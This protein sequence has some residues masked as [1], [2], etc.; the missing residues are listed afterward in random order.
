MA[1]QNK[2][3]IFAH[4]PETYP[5]A[6]R[7]LIIES[8][9]LDLDAPLPEG[10]V[11]VK[12]LVLSIDPVFRRMMQSQGDSFKDIPGYVLG[13][14][15]SGPVFGK[16]LRSNNDQFKQDDFV[17]TL[18]GQV[19]EYAVYP[20]ELAP[21]LIVR[22]E[23]KTSG[24]PI[25]HYLNGLGFT[26]FTAYV[27]LFLVANVQ[28]GQSIYI[29]AAAGAVGHI[30]GQLAKA[31]GLRV[32][33]SAG[34]DE[35]V[36]ILKEI[37]FDGA[38]NY[39]TDDADA[40]LKEFEPNGIDIYFDN[41]GSKQLEL[42]IRHLKPFGKI[43]VCGMVSTY[44][45]PSAAPPPNNLI[46]IVG[47]RLQING[48]MAFVDYADKFGD[49][50]A[51]TTPLILDGKLKPLETTAVGIEQVPQALVDVFHGGNVGKQL[52]KLADN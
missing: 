51:Y 47:K 26:G 44:N 5:V 2:Q 13:Q 28:K 30:T 9:D 29:S 40:K 8:H 23:P 50:L 25:H 10:A 32:Y 22:N 33:G 49:F 43:L 27:G 48:F 37:G 39:K 24:L 34:S 19:S 6:G 31:H 20:R 1:I 38:F 15:I 52:V 36:A 21:F 16:V 4:V 46:D 42:A 14:P 41:V 17:I 35:K 11:L 45:D 7:D 3:V 18:F 12:S